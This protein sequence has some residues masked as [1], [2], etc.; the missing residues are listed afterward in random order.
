MQ[1]PKLKID[2]IVTELITEE[3][4]KVYVDL[5]IFCLN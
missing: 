4:I 5:T 2:D 3:F 1:E